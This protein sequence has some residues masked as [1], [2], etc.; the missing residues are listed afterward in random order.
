MLQFE[1]VTITPNGIFAA[2]AV[3]FTVPAPPVFTWKLK[4]PFADPPRVVPIAKS[5][6][7]REPTK[8]EW[9]QY[10]AVYEV[11]I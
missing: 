5:N 8:E 2:F 3:P 9:A 6:K 4:K 1:A 11:C 10:A 7:A